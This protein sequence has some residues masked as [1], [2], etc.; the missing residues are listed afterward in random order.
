[1]NKE[2]KDPVIAGQKKPSAS[3]KEGEKPSQQ[4]IE[5]DVLNIMEYRK[6]MLHGTEFP[7]A[8][9]LKKYKS[10]STN[11][12]LSASIDKLLKELEGEK[13]GD[14]PGEKHTHSE[15]TRQAPG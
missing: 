1:M 14:K 7:Y 6:K 13:S 4:E 15:K 3:L 8:E 12:E 2:K 9:K 10:M 5:L 11:K